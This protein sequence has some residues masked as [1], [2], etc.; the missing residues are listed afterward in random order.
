ML[1][2]GLGL[3]GHGV[4]GRH[5]VVIVHMVSVAI[6]LAERLVRGGRVFGWRGWVS[7]VLAGGRGRGGR[8]C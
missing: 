5:H 8:A 3:G 4:V 2:G 7:E 1:G 6:V